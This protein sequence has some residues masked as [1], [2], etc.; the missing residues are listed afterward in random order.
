MGSPTYPRKQ[1][2][3]LVSRISWQHQSQNHFL[4]VLLLCE[5]VICVRMHPLYQLH[6][7]AVGQ[8]KHFRIYLFLLRLL[9]ELPLI[10]LQKSGQNPRA[11]CLQQTHVHAAASA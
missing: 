11:L 1:K 3:V 7:T 9:S 4:L 8:N 2:S 6:V 5:T 10:H